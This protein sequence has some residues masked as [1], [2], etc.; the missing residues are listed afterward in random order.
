MIWSRTSG[1]RTTSAKP[2]GRSCAACPHNA[3]INTVREDPRRK[4]LLFAG[5]ERAVW[6][7]FNDGDDWAPLRLNMPATSIR[8]VTIH[9]DD[10]V[11]GTHG[12]SFWILDDITPLRQMSA[13]IAGS[14]AHLFK[15]Q[16]A[17]RVRWNKNTDTPL[18]PEEPGGQN[19]PDGAIL[20]Y[21]LKNA[22]DSVGIEVLDAD[23]Q[24]GAALLE[25][26]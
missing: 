15:P 19:P 23:G 3:P 6:V 17:I 2:G 4:G 18:P 24:V 21:Y 26:R 16:T 20:Y 10:L 1:A 13:A 8:D 12:R 5:S 11:A 7:S 14:A 25:R 9:D 22:S